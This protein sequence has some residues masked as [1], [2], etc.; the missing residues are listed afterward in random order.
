VFFEKP[1]RLKLGRKMEYE[2]KSFKASVQPGGEGEIT[3]LVSCFGNIDRANEKVMPG[4]FKASLQRKLP[5]GVWAHDWTQPIAKTLE[6]RETGDGLV[7]KG[8]FNLDTQ[9]GREAYSNI[10]FGIIDEFSIGYRVVKDSRDAESKNI[11]NLDELELFEWSPVLVGLNEN[12]QLLSIKSEVPAM[13]G[14]REVD[15]AV[16]AN[17]PNFGGSPMSWSNSGNQPAEEKSFGQQFIESNAY[18]EFLRGKCHGES[19]AM[20]VDISVK[21]LMTT[22]TGWVPEAVRSTVVVPYATPQPAVTDIIP[23]IQTRQNA[24]VYMEETTFTNAAVETAEGALKPE[25]ALALTER[26]APIRKIPV[27]VPVTDEQLEDVPEIQ[28]YLENRLSLMVRQRL[29]SQLLVGDGVTPNLQ[30]ILTMPG[31]QTQ[32]KGVDPTPD[33]IYKALTKCQVNGQA[34]PNYVIM[35][36]N[37]WS[38]IRLLRTT[39]G[40]YIWGSP[41][42]TGVNRIWGLPVLLAQGMAEGTAIVGDFANYSLLVERKGVSIK[43]GYTGD[44]FVHNIRTVLAEIRVAAVW[45]RPSAFCLCTGI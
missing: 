27:H 30:G 41:S 24:F 38:D 15:P 6:A 4:A 1:T 33:C 29:D 34:T 31:V 23:T 13:Y 44:Q 19:D 21:T 12:T 26:S 2:R 28:T 42:E 25:A 22:T 14:S 16:K 9:A 45:T 11:R 3:A 36:P 17:R 20:T 43:V 8:K 40:L 7:I 32:A 37:D 35:H 10:K 18:Q 39:D 5:K